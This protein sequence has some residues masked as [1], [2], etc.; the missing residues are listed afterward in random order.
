MIVKC[1]RYL[2]KDV[3]Y[4]NHCQDRLSCGSHPKSEYVSLSDLYKKKFGGKE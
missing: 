2:Y 3:S 1:P 4:C